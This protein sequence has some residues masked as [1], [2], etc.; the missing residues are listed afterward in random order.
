MS[1]LENIGDVELSLKDKKIKLPM[2]EGT[3]GERCMDITKLN[4]MLLPISSMSSSMIRRRNNQ[5][6]SLRR[7]RMWRTRKGFFVLGKNRK[8]IS[9]A[10]TAP[11][12][13]NH[14]W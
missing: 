6:T 11:T 10:E 14:F 1:G 13:D 7:S 2:C 3:E 8:A 4:L 9:P 12:N 5:R